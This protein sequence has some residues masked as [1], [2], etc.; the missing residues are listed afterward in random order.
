MHGERTSLKKCLKNEEKVG[1]QLKA[2]EFVE[3]AIDLYR[4][5]CLL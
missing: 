2:D 4:I 5:V 3:Q 1:W